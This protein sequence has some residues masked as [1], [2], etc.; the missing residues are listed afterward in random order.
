MS[1]AVLWSNRGLAEEETHDYW[2]DWPI[3]YLFTPSPTTSNLLLPL[4]WQHHIHNISAFA[5]TELFLSLIF[6]CLALFPHVPFGHFVIYHFQ[7]FTVFNFSIIIL[8]LLQCTTHPPPTIVTKWVTTC[9]EAGCGFNNIGLLLLLFLV[10]LILTC[11][12]SWG[13]TGWKGWKAWGTGEIWRWEATT[14]AGKAV[15]A[16]LGSWALS[17]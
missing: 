17:K 3:F 4:S 9:H 10:L 1:S 14:K 8:T 5:T 13:H 7:F 2:I 6:T 16:E 15:S 12:T 11:Q